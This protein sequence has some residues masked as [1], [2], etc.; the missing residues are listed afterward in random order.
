MDWTWEMIQS[1]MDTRSWRMWWRKWSNG[2][3]SW[4][5]KYKCAMTRVIFWLKNMNKLKYYNMLLLYGRVVNCFYPLKFPWN[6]GFKHSKGWK[7]LHHYYGCKCNVLDMILC[8]MAVHQRKLQTNVKS[9]VIEVFC[10]YY[11]KKHEPA[12]SYRSSSLKYDERNSHGK[13]GLWMSCRTGSALPVSSEQR[14]GVFFIISYDDNG[15]LW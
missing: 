10:P 9:V 6:D 12:D 15:F 13:S 2:K 5:W 7:E 14:C 4:K 1:S 8:Q 11:N 3:Q